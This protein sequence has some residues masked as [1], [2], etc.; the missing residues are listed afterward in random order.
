MSLSYAW[1]KFHSA[2]LTLSGSGDHQSRIVDAFAFNIVHVNRK[3]DIPQPLLAE[4]D[5]LYTR[6]TAIEPLTNEGSINASVR[7]MTEPELT[8]ISDDI[9]SLYDSLCRH[10]A[11]EDGS[12]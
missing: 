7:L 10:L 4:F 1:E 6:L 8:K 11:I 3:E 12:A 5:E 2:V 9:V